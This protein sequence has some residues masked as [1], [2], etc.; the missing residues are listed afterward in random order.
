MKGREEDEVAA[1]KMGN[2]RTGIRTGDEKIEG[3][4]RRMERKEGGTYR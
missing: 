4:V 2:E 3:E 1:G